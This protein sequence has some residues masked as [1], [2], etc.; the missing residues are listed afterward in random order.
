MSNVHYFITGFQHMI[1]RVPWTLYLHWGR[2]TFTVTMPVWWCRD[3]HC[4][5]SKI[6]P[7]VFK[8]RRWTLIK[9]DFTCLP[10]S[11]YKAFVH[12]RSNWNLT[13][14]GWRKNQTTR[15]KTVRCKEE[16]QHVNGGQIL[17]TYSIIG[18]VYT[19]K[20]FKNNNLHL[21]IIA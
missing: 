20:I 1:G 4:F 15:R 19:Y 11:T 14:R 18:C 7:R 5:T 10:R 13:E 9:Y 12:R 3:H 8:P 2:A 17:F 21:Q 6:P 16:E